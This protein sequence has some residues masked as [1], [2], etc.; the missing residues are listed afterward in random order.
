MW[1]FDGDG[2]GRV[3]EFGKGGK[4]AEKVSIGIAEAIAEFGLGG[5]GAGKNVVAVGIKRF[6]A[7]TVGTDKGGREKREAETAKESKAVGAVVKAMVFVL[8]RHA[9]EG[10][11]HPR[12]SEGGGIGS[13]MRE[14]REGRGRM[15]VVE[16]ME[17]TAEAAKVKRGVGEGG[18]DMGSRVSG[19]TVAENGLA[20]GAEKAKEAKIG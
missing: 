11:R 20:I 19:E 17:V 16:A 5:M 6:A 12:G 4:G 15:F 9:V 3:S 8:A 13:E 18:E 2:V 7:G 14:R 1:S 10:K